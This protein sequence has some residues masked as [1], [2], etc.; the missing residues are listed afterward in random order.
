MFFP[1]V[2]ISV[3]TFLL[4]L[5]LLRSG[6]NEN[7]RPEPS[8]PS[9]RRRRVAVVG[10]GPAGIVMLRELAEAG[11]DAVAFGYGLTL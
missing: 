4:F 9:V 3:A 1:I 7:L 5:H 8:Q 10:A 6:N 11:H 2:I